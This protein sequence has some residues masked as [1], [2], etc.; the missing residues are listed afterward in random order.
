[1]EH[2]AT[3][4]AHFLARLEALQRQVPGVAGVRGRG[5]MLA[6]D[7]EEPRAAEVVGFA[8]DRGLLLNNTGPSTLRMVPPLII[9]HEQ[10]DTAVD[11]LAAILRTL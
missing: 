7:L 6:L 2:A 1:M 11:I 8:R 5:L 4:G 10:I 9:S 3:A